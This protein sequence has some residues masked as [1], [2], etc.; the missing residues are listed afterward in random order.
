VPGRRKKDGANNEPEGSWWDMHPGPAS[1]DGMFT[2][3]IKANVIRKLS[4]I[5]LLWLKNIGI[6]I[7]EGSS[8]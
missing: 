4:Y 1:S 7:F 6:V 2:V 3:C 5:G 8:L